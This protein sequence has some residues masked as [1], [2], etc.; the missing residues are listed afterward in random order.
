MTTK[1]TLKEYKVK[2]GKQCEY[3]HN[4]T[5]YCCKPWEDYCN[6][7]NEYQK[8]ANRA[9]SLKLSFEQ[10]YFLILGDYSGDAND[11]SWLQTLQRCELDNETIVK[12]IGTRDEDNRKCI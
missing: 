3:D 4:E 10:I 2:N 12:I 1:T 9:L 8:I 6:G 5:G 7:I 11:F